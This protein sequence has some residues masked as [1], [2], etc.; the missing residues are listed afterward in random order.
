MVELLLAKGAEIDLQTGGGYGTALQAASDRGH[1]D[2]VELLIARGAEVC[3]FDYLPVFFSIHY[4]LVCLKRIQ[5]ASPSYIC[6]RARV[7]R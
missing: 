4:A 3:L 6:C 2:I 7:T 5:A 1:K